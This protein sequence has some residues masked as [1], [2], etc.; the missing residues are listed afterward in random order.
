MK[1]TCVVCTERKTTIRKLLNQ[2]RR[3]E[4]RGEPTQPLVDHIKYYKKLIRECCGVPA[5]STQ[6]VLRG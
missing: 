5:T 4:S 1:L 6:P 2:I 3:A